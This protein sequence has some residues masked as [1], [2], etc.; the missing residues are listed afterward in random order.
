VLRLQSRALQYARQVLYNLSH[1]L[2][3]PYFSDKVSSFFPWGWTLD[4]NPPTYAYCITGITGVY[5]MSSLIPHL[6]VTSKSYLLTSA[7][8]PAVSYILVTGL[9]APCLPLWALSPLSGMYSG[10]SYPPLCH[11]YLTQAGL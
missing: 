2:F 10:L 9:L 5:T 4:H 3:L 7:H 6:K 1:Q 8:F 11:Q